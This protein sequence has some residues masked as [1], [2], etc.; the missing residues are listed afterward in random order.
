[1]GIVKNLLKLLYIYSDD[2]DLKRTAR[3]FLFFGSQNIDL[4]ILMF[5]I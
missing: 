4:D 3:I 5:I 2:H 1:M